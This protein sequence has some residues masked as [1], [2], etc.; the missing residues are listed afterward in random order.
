MQN[1]QRK[2]PLALLTSSALA[3]ILVASGCDKK[4][5][6]THAPSSAKQ[7]PQ[8]Q[9]K[10]NT[11]PVANAGNDL[12]VR[13][14]EVI[15]LNGTQSSDPDHDLMTFTWTQTEGPTVELINADTLSPSFVAPASKKPLAFSLVVNDGQADSEVDTVNVTISNR[16]PT[17]NA[18]RTIIAKRGS[19]VSLDGGGSADPD[20]DDITYKWEQVYGQ[21]VNIEGAN[22]AFPTFT[23]PDASG[24]LIFA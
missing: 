10:F 23:M 24:I 7:A 5:T 22:T 1:R 16:A 2:M 21:I 19:I 11:P 6:E 15:T 14:G 17:A 3:L 20:A 12:I 9:V 4:S 13:V 18:G 8:V